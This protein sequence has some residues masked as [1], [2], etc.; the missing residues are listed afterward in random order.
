M[1]VVGRREDNEMHATYKGREKYNQ[2]KQHSWDAR[3]I[4]ER[5]ES[6]QNHIMA[7]MHEKKI[8]WHAHMRSVT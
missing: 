2:K 8:S 7:C 5:D 1:P 4:W 6:E 3:G